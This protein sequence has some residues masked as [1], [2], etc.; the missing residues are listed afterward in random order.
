[1]KC[2]LGIW[3]FPFFKKERKKERKKKKEREREKKKRKIEQFNIICSRIFCIKISFHL[4]SEAQ[5]PYS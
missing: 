1:M 3:I 5:R 4:E 2:R